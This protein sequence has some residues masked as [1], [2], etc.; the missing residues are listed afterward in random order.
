MAG[1]VG[2]DNTLDWW[3]LLSEALAFVAEHTRSEK[4]AKEVLEGA[5]ADRAPVNGPVEWRCHT[6]AIDAEATIPG[7]ADPSGNPVQ[8]LLV[9]RRYFWRREDHSRIEIEWEDSCAIRIG[10]TIRIGVNSEDENDQ[11]P[12]FDG[13]YRVKL[14]ATLIRLN[15]KG[16]IRMLRGIGLMPPPAPP[17]PSPSPPT[18]EPAAESPPAQE[19]PR[20]EAER[21]KPL[22]LPEEPQIGEYWCQKDVKLWLKHIREKHPQMP[23]ESKSVWARRLHEHMKTDFGA[24]I[25]WRE[26]NTV[27]RRIHDPDYD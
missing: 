9:A 4:A 2:D 23:G 3:P 12:I 21:P 11:W 24:N 26:W 17:S 7:V 19:P 16:L 15:G 20:Q 18:S 22:Q 5:L 25:P 14:R 10:P 6:F 1:T 13:R 27:L 8:S